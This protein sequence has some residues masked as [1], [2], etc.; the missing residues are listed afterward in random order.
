[1]NDEQVMKLMD[2]L[3][4]LSERIA[5]VE[6]MLRDRATELEE[7]NAI[8]KQHNDRIAILEQNK[9]SL[10]DIVGFVGWAVATAIAIWSVVF[11]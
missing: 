3:S 1:M 8:L 4:E 5:R 11:K 9:A 6:T 10:H 7:I 2:K